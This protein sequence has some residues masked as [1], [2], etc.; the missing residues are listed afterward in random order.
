MNAGD[1]IRQRRDRILYNSEQGQT[2]P[3]NKRVAKDSQL[4]INLQRG[5]KRVYYNNL[6]TLPACECS[7]TPTPPPPPPPF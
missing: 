2:K 3:E 6:T 7:T 1:L 4:I 5:P